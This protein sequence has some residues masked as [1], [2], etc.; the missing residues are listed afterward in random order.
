LINSTIVQE[1]ESNNA[2]RAVQVL[3]LLARSAKV[4]PVLDETGKETGSKEVV[5]K[6]RDIDATTKEEVQI[7]LPVAKA[8]KRMKELP[9][10]YGNLFRGEEK[11][12]TGHMNTMMGR[13]TPKG[14]DL[15]SPQAY[16]D[17]VAKNPALVSNKT[18]G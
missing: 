14:L 8:I 18:T 1:A 15:S 12:G 4:K 7:T 5:V 9:E 3:D 17:S 13:P 10:Y 2:I 6:I 16:F 11:G